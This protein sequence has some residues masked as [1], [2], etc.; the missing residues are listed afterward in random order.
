VILALVAIVLLSVQTPTAPGHAVVVGRW[1]PGTFAALTMWGVQA[2]VGKF[3]LRTVRPESLF[4]Y[5]TA[6]AVVLCPIAWRMTD[7]GVPINWGLTGPVLTTAIQFP[8]SLGALLSTYAMRA[9]KATIVSP[10]TNGLYPVIAIVLSLFIY[11]RIP[12]RWNVV[13]MVL[14]ITGIVLMSYGEALREEQLTAEPS[15]A[16]PASDVVQS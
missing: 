10:T 16:L 9:G 15:A 1:L 3:A 2:Y 12:E 4:F 7:F 13:G 14:A 6:A 5:M 11:A 8:N